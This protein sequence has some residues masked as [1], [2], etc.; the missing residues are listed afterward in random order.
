MNNIQ[1]EKKDDSTLKTSS[2][3]LGGAGLKT[4]RFDFR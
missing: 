3:P 1:H 4:V 2:L